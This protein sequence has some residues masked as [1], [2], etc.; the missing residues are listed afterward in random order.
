[1]M[2]LKTSCMLSL[3]RVGML[4]GKNDGTLLHQKFHYKPMFTRLVKTRYF[5]VN[6][7]VIDL[8]REMMV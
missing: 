2:P 8:T 1:M 4:Y 6:V 7:V 5:F 3:K